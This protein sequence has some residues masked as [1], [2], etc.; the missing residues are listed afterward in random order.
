MTKFSTFLY[1]ISDA[2]A[3]IGQSFAHLRGVDIFIEW[4]AD[5]RSP[6]AFARV[7]GHTCGSTEYWGFGLHVVVSPLRV[8]PQR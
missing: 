1:D 4:D 3:S 8:S 6:L 7:T 2:L 5:G